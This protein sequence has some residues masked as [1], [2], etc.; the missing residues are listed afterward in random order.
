[1]GVSGVTICHL[2]AV[3]VSYPT[4]CRAFYSTA[5]IP[6]AMRKE[7]RPVTGLASAPQIVDSVRTTVVL[8]AIVSVV[9][10]KVLL[11]LIVMVAVIVLIVLL[12]SGAIVLLE[13]INHAA[14]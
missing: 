1:M 7:V 9:F 10:W 3:P 4:A 13:S 14:G 11:K 6:Q 12:T 8:F 2:L 5:F